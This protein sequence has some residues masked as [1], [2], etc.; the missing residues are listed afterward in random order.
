V[1]SAGR[2]E[3][4][5]ATVSRSATWIVAHN[6]HLQKTRSREVLNAPHNRDVPRPLIRIGTI[7]P[8]VTISCGDEMDVTAKQF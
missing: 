1:K 2:L 8:L 3:L 4:L 5:E 7:V 6:L